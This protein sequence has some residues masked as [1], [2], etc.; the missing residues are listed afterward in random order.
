MAVDVAYAIGLEPKEA[1][2]YLRSMGVQVAG[3]WRESA[4]AAKSHAFAIAGV[5][6]AS[7]T[8]DIHAAIARGI[9]K[10]Q[11]PEQIADGLKPQLQAAGW[12][13][14]N[15]RDAKGKTVPGTGE[16]L[17]DGK[18]LTH[19]RLKFIAQEQMA[20]AY[21]ASKEKYASQNGATRWQYSAILDSRTRPS[22]RAMHGKMF[23]TDDNA[24][25]SFKPRN[26]FR[27]RCT[28][29]YFWDAPAVLAATPKTQTRTASTTTE[30]GLQQTTSELLDKGLPGGVFRPDPGF[31]RSP[32]AAWQKASLSTYALEKAAKLPPELG[33]T[34]AQQQLAQPANV[35][36]VSRDFG[37]MV[38][39][40]FKRNSPTG[41][42]A[43]AGFMGQE[44]IAYLK[45]LKIVPATSAIVVPDRLLVGPKAVRHIR[46]GDGLSR[47]EWKRV[48]AALASDE[49]LVLYDV[50]RET[51]LYVFDADAG[52]STKLVVT[53]NQGV[54]GQPNQDLASSGFKIET[55][56][57]A[58]G[59][60]AK[61]YLV[62]RGKL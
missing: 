11:T 43:I 21:E 4:A 28:S 40:A 50:D 27:C 41:K 29:I 12:W 34:I 10:G 5:T 6:Q 56:H 19:S 30:D 16:I 45:G 25:S 7:V 20:N 33:A 24:A 62:V 39:A 61:K 8:A 42:S 58:D 13:G 47:A 17:P 37:V 26:G 57:I 46:D 36:Q 60:K 54:K 55:R 44:E 35:A 49:L 15:A 59:I 9:A 38:D 52:R 23:R 2:S 14:K 1:V 31:D 48:P 53:A 18:G 3:D 51:L 32:S 22:H